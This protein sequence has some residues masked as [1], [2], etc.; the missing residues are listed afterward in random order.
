MVLLEILQ[1]VLLTN[2]MTPGDEADID[3]L[4]WS[5]DLSDR[6]LTSLRQLLTKLQAGTI[7]RLGKVG[8]SISIWPHC[9]S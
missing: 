8:G 6:E 4:L 7:V 3:Y 5:Q 1:Q 2:V 9:L